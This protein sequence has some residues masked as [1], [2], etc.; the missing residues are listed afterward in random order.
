[1]SSS[2]RLTIA[3]STPAVRRLLKFRELRRSRSEHPSGSGRFPEKKPSIHAAANS[4]GKLR[5]PDLCH[6]GAR[7][8]RPPS[9]RGRDSSRPRSG[10]RVGREV[11]A[12]EVDLAATRSAG[13][14]I[15]THGS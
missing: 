2:T 4:K 7:V 11:L 8:G 1:M 15:G 5:L 14:R 13:V 12:G 10:E 6:R 9:L 3:I